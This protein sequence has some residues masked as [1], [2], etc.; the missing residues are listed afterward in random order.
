M[1]W[2][3]REKRDFSILSNYLL[4]LKVKNQPMDRINKI[5]RIDR[6]DFYSLSC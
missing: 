1:R 6:I 4:L 3:D 5:D 2:A